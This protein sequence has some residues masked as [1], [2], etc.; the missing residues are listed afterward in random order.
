MMR[1][2]KFLRSHWRIIVPILVACLA[3]LAL[4][5]YRLGSLTGGMN[6]SEITAATTPVGWHGI[7][8]QPFYLPLEVVR[9]I[10][11]GLSPQ[12]GQFLSRLPNV[13][14]GGLSIICFALLIYLW[15][16]RR[17]MILTTALFACGAWTLHV[18][19]LASLDVLYLWALPML[20]LT[21]V[22]QHRFVK[23]PA[24]YFGS[25]LIWAVLLYIPGLVWLIAINCWWQRRE[26]TIGW[27]QL[28]LRRQKLVAALIA[29][30]WIPLL[31]L[32]FLRTPASLKLWLGLPASLAPP[33][34]LLKHFTGVFV[35]LFV[36]GPEYPVQWLG[37]M[38]VLDLFSLVIALLGIYFYAQHVRAARSR[39]LFGFFILG[40]L[41]V[42]L[43]GPVGLS[44]LVPLLYVWAAAGLAYL[45]Q[46][47]LVVFPLNPLAR[48]LGIGLISLTV[49]LS[50]L[51]NV[52]AY[53]IAWPDNPSTQ[54]AF[55]IRR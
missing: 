38:P 33:K 53:F 13:V 30:I 1:F 40:V 47:W 18:S 28:K 23:R 46:R 29:V 11:F 54:A 35:H 55:R 14:F 7:Y 4:L 8:H 17:T 10:V 20:L 41:L 15:H 43:G 12:H 32:E 25:M 2:Q 48:G 39:M 42:S 26:L 27:R 45:L 34:T 24:V 5:L 3:I 9:S 22:L 16:G 44:L 21:N 6:S 31:L 52:R 50:C 19:R 36:R 51:Y 37:R 49:A